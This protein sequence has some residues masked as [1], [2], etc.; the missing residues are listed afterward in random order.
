MCIMLRWCFPQF[1]LLSKKLRGS[2][3]PLKRLSRKIIKLLRLERNRRLR[4]PLM[5]A[6]R[7]L[8]A[9]GLWGNTRAFG[10]FDNSPPQAGMHKMCKG[11][12]NQVL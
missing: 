5:G 7:I 6:M 3:F 11:V 9:E 12:L 10:I 1:A 4:D 8:P 2:N